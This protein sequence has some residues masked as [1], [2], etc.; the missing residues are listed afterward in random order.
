MKKIALALLL[1]PWGALAQNPNL[2]LSPGKLDDTQGQ[3]HEHARQHTAF[4]F[5]HRTA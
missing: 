5:R 1:T 2:I 4:Q 3:A